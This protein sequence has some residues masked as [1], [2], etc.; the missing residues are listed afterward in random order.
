MTE[1]QHNAH[2]HDRD[3]RAQAMARHV[4]QESA[5]FVVDPETGEKI[6]LAEMIAPPIA[7]P[8]GLPM[9]A[10]TSAELRRDSRR[11]HLQVAA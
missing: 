3:R 2:Q 5:P 4:A 11:T 9:F 10:R 6:Y 7:P 8:I 1:K